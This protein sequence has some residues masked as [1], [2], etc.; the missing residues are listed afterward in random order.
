VIFDEH[1]IKVGPENPTQRQKDEKVLKDGY[2]TYLP[3]DCANYDD[4]N[5]LFQDP[6][7]LQAALPNLFNQPKHLRY[8]ALKKVDW[9]SALY[10][11]N[12]KTHREIHSWW[13]VFAA[14]HRLWF[15]HVLLYALSMWWVSSRSFHDPGS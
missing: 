10:S 9:A 11:M 2:A 1:Y 14:T 3:P 4:W 15:L 12:V 7:R 6:K 13:G 5:E 8:E